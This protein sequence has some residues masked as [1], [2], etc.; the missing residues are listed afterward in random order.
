MK[1]KNKGLLGAVFQVFLTIWAA[2]RA[3]AMIAT[4]V[5]ALRALWSSSRRRRL[6][7]MSP[8]E[9]FGAYADREY[10]RE[11]RGRRLER[12]ATS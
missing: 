7:R 11:R 10:E 4:G 8:R 12:V 5:S 6:A 3:F 2:T 1:R 9:R